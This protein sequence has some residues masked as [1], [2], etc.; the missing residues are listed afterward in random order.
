MSKE[1]KFDPFAGYVEPE[2]MGIDMED[3]GIMLLHRKKGEE[4]ATV[5][6][7]K[8]EELGCSE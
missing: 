3:G 1:Q 5:T 4:S 7:L 6:I 2:V 8:P